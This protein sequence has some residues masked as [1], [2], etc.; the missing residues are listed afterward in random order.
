[1]IYDSD[2]DVEV[3]DISN[4]R[5]KIIDLTRSSDDERSTE[6]GEDSQTT[7]EE[8]EE[9]ESHPMSFIKG[10]GHKSWMY[11]INNY[12]DTDEKRLQ[13][14]DCT[15]HVY[16]RE[17][18]ESGTPHLQGCI[19]FNTAMR[20][21]AASR[22]LGGH[23]TVPRVL[24]QARNYCMKDSDCYIKDNRKQGERTDIQQLSDMIA[25]GASVREAALKHSTVYVKY[26]QGF[27]DLATYHQKAR[28]EKP[29][30][31]WLH[32]DTGVGKTS[33][34]YHVEDPEE[35]WPSSGDLAYFNGYDNQRIALL[36]DF[37]GNFCKF[38]FLLRL[39]DRYPLWVN[40][41]HGC[42]QWTVSRIYITSCRTPEGCYDKSDEDMQ[43][44]LRR[45]DVIAC[46]SRLDSSSE[47]RSDGYRVPQFNYSKG[48]DSDW[49]RQLAQKFSKEN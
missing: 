20:F 18:G 9:P 8:F 13:S 42:R 23:L 3:V 26:P 16:G 19:T 1:M 32:G 31:V 48:G 37:R 5:A 25:S 30:V 14:L 38:R 4:K 40:V 17:I 29:L 45:I 49:A 7:V 35:I 43:Q 41:K 46:V 33:T 2:S 12:T 28:K 24:D 39:L 10:R 11:T 34:V 15:F 47:S 36:D 6:S 27:K 44:L 22:V 21:N